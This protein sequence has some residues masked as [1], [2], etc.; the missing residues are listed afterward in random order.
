MKFSEK[1]TIYIFRFV[2]I[3]VI[4]FTLTFPFPYYT[5]PNFGSWIAPIFEPINHFWANLFGLK[6]LDLRIYS[7][8]PGLFLHLITI[9]VV[10]TIGSAVWCVITN[11][12]K[13][14]RLWYWFHASISYCLALTLF[15]YGFD[16]IFKHQFYF[17]EPNT[18]F[19]PIGELTPDILY[20]SSMGTSY[21]YSL[22]S[23]LLEIIPALLLLFRKTRFSGGFIA[24]AVL[25][26]IVMI[27]F[28]FDISVKV[29]SIYLLF[30][31]LVII[32]P[33]L[34]NLKL[35]FFSNQSTI[36][37]FKPLV[38]SSK[39]NLFAYAFGKPL[40]IGLI[41]FE[42]LSPYF[43]TQNFNDDLSEKPFLHGAYQVDTFLIDDQLI[44]PSLNHSDR[45]KRFFIHRKS[46]FIIQYMDDSFESLK[47]EYITDKP[48]LKVTDKYNRTSLLTINFNKDFDLL[49]I[50]GHFNAIPIKLESHK[51]PLD[52]LPLLKAM[53]TNNLFF[54]GK[55]IL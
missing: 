13:E 9:S 28:G 17:P 32:S 36:Q 35:F 27:N 33:N 6:I 14:I 54:W 49:N 19:T 3:F 20:W 1:Y 22:F 39:K 8:S 5:L 31:S 40:V 51:I 48:Q 18:L 4:F 21:H 46:Y 12:K 45:F 16:K 50:S 24:F 43:V 55:F 44:S 53:L 11:W 47:M 34:N 23:G 2:F 30:L 42:A 37:Q 26:N 38:I 29:F 10:S 7:D 15:K 41:L 52:S 25:L